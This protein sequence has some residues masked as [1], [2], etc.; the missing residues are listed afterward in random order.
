LVSWP[1]ACAVYND[2]MLGLG[3]GGSAPLDNSVG[4][5]G[6]GASGKGGDSNTGKTGGTSAAQAGSAPTAGTA[7]ETLA[8]SGGSGNMPASGGDGSTDGG[9][10]SGGASGGNGGSG[11]SSGSGA[12]SGG[13]G[14]AGGGNGGAPTTAGTSGTAGNSGSAGG[15]GGPSI[16]KCSDHPLTARASWTATA[17]HPTSGDMPANLLDGKITRWSTG[18]AQSGDEWLQI[19]FGATVTINHVN[20]QQ[21]DDTN[22][23]PRTYSVIV[24]N[25]AK[26][27]GGTARGTGSGKSGVSTAILLP[28]LATGRYL[29]IKQT[30]TSLSWWSAEE[31][32]ISCSD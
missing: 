26:D 19:D 15:G 1:F 23:Y 31:I 4:G 5:A 21:G 29:L 24:S 7:S 25:T 3:L 16:P 6:A 17:S 27:L 2:D 32:E 12:G 13:K 22:D 9:E 11:G 28:A 14:G 8:G 20:L 10:A 18:K 30:A